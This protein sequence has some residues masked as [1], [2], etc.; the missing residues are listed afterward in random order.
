M[1]EESINL[2][3]IALTVLD[4]AGIRETPDEIERIGV[5]LSHAAMAKADLVL[6]VVDVTEGLMRKIN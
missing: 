2:G 4:T 3:G 6:F 1:L 5:E